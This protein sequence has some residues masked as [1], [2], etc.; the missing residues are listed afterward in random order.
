MDISA[1]LSGTP[2]IV[3]NP[4]PLVTGQHALQAVH[5]QGNTAAGKIQM[6][7]VANAFAAAQGMTELAAATNVANAVFTFLAFGTAV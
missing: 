2:I 3:V 7:Q 1:K 6:F 4:S 5:N